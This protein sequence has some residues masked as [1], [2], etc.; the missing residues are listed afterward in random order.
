M[1]VDE[2][3]FKALNGYLMPNEAPVEERALYGSLIGIYSRWQRGALTKDEAAA[4]KQKAVARYNKD[5]ELAEFDTKERNRMAGFW[6]DIET[7]VNAYRLSPSVES[8][9][10]AINTIY[11]V[12]RRET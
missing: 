10:L 6:K 3:S 11:N 5:R 4:E 2:I 8:A 12:S 1:T 7:V 9:D